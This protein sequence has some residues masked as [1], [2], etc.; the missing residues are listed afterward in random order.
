MRGTFNMLIAWNTWRRAAAIALVAAFTIAA[1]SRADVIL[2]EDLST[3][4]LPAWTGFG[5]AIQ[6]SGVAG[7]GNALFTDEGN[8]PQTYVET[9]TLS[10]VAGGTY[11]FSM[12]LSAIGGCFFSGD[13]A[14]PHR[15]SVFQNG[16]CI[17]G[18]TNFFPSGIAIRRPLEAGDFTHV[19]VTFLATADTM[20][21]KI[22]D[23]TP[24][25]DNNGGIGVADNFLLTG[26]AR[27]QGPGGVPEPATWALMIAGLG[28]AGAALRRRGVALA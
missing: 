16:D 11:T 5:I 2:S 22:L 28:L 18:C 13:C 3:G 17:N 14:G 25:P 6:D 26:P 20:V 9:P 4:S 12:D 27:T 21:L 1:Q 8:V 7:Y 23:S 19:S 24:Y 15:F 10:V